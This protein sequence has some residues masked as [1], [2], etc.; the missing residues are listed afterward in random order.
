MFENRFSA[1]KMNRFKQ[2]MKHADKPYRCLPKREKKKKSQISGIVKLF[3][4]RIETDPEDADP[5]NPFH[6]YMRSIRIDR[7]LSR[8]FRLRGSGESKTEKIS[9]RTVKSALVKAAVKVGK[10]FLH[11]FHLY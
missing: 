11:I 5:V 3:E 1:V 8:P 7:E 6:I 4:R 10:F 9:K 2:E